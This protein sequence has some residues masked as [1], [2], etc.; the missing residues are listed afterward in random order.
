MVLD[1]YKGH[2]R[3]WHYG[4]TVGFHTAIERFR[5][6]DLSIIVLCNRTDVSPQELALKVANLYLTAEKPTPP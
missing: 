4:K 6:Q 3:M 5:D 2:P 1:S